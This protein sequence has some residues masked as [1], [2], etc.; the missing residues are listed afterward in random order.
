MFKIRS[1]AECFLSNAASF[2]ADCRG[3][4]ATTLG[5]SVMAVA[6]AAGVAV[7]YSRLA[8]AKSAMDDSL[9][10]ALLAA[11]AEMSAGNG[12]ESEI[13]RTFEDFLEANLASRSILRHGVTIDDLAI[14]AGSGRIAAKTSSN[15]VSRVH[16]MFFF[17]FKISVPTNVQSATKSAKGILT[18]NP[19]A[20]L[21]GFM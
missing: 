6:L 1:L 3:T 15:I 8:Q 14:D 5:V 11:G 19:Q 10:A 17:S 13:R 16:G 7:D 12:S 9:D 2:E 20:S 4:F 18:A 21:W